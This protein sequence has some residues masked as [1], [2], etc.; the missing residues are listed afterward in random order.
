M[1]C[2]VL[3]KGCVSSHIDKQDLMGAKD[4]VGKQLFMR[5][6]YLLLDYWNHSVKL[7]PLVLILT[8]L[9]F[10]KSY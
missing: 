4:Y 10:P 7:V 1:I 5:T 9:A 3:T 8:G 2:C 6:N